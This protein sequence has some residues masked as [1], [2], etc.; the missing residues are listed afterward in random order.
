MQEALAE[1][2]LGQART[3]FG[4][5]E[6]S[7]A[8]EWLTSVP[9]A[10]HPKDLVAM[11]HGWLAKEAVAR[12]LWGVA[13]DHIQ[14][15]LA[16]GR[17]PLLERRLYL[18]RHTAP[19]LDD[20]QWHFLRSKVD[21]AERQWPSKLAPEI[22]G[23]YSCGAYHAWTDRYLPW[24]R[25]LRIAK[26]APRD[27]DEGLAALRLAGEF[28]CRVVS[29]ETPLLRFVDVVVA[30]PANAARYARRMMSLPDE[31]ARS[32]ESHFALPF[33]FDA[34]IS[35]APDNLELRGLS[36][37]ERQEAIRGSMR[38]GNLGIGAG[39]TILLV[40]DITTSGATLQEGARRLR[41]AGA[42]DVYAVTLS[43]TEG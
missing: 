1:F 26:E 42:S 13:E 4:N 7:E 14:K 28:L 39:R 3:C 38:V 35:E 25:F 19:L 23:V 10:Q 32:L 21:P 40:D 17:H 18:V 8:L 41:E 20:Y 5:A 15:A 2:A 33:L 36:W 11:A 31:L 29:E 30:I 43:H 37:R 24:S 34:L 6:W 12:G 16:A 9:Q 27:T 22:T